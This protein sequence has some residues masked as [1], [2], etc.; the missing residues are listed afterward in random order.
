MSAMGK[1]LERWRRAVAT[2]DVENPTHESYGIGLAFFDLERLGLT[3]G[4]E[5]WTGY[6]VQ[7]D[8][9]A[10]GNFRVLC[11][12]NH[13]ERQPRTLAEKEQQEREAEAPLHVV[14]PEREVTHA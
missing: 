9:K 8:G 5:L 4:E 6:T 3:E 1:N 7:V 13:D 10:S 14:T 11:D 2:H 12:G